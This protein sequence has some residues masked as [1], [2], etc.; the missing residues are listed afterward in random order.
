MT[1]TNPQS[2]DTVDPRRLYTYAEAAAYYGG[3]VTARR[4]RRW[5][6]DGKHPYVELPGGRGRRISGQ[7]LLDTIDKHAVA[8]AV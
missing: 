3:D 1:Q 4:V 5:V 7:Q 2:I 6:E 8:A